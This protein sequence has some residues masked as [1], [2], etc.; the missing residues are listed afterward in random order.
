M[1][2]PRF[3]IEL[4]GPHHDRS[5][6][7]CGEEPLDR[8]FQRQA[9]QD[10]K[11]SLAG[12]FVLVDT[13]T[14]RVTGFYTLS[15]LSVEATDLP[16]DVVR[17]LPLHPLP[18]T[19]IGRLAIDLNYQGQR[20]GKALL[21]DALQRAY[22]HRRQ[23]GSIAVV[24]DAKHDRARAFYERHEFRRFPENAYRLFLTMKTIGSLVETGD[25]PSGRDPMRI[26]GAS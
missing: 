21:F 19:L 16:E 13:E 22:Q 1:P 25:D 2:E 23:I 7:A 11:R 5:S 8:Y 15:A 4:F 12:I 6:F 9:G 10:V 24:V 14:D 17:K 26:P 20:L 3:R 18:A